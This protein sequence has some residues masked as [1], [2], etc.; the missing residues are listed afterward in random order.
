MNGV[1]SKF[2]GRKLFYGFRIWEC[3]F[4]DYQNFTIGYNITTKRS[5]DREL[6]H[7]MRQINSVVIVAVV[8]YHTGADRV[9]IGSLIIAQ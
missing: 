7:T 8:N 3:R 1:Q 5:E 9:V 4:E 6:N 2:L